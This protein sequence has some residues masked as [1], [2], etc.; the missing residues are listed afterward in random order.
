PEGIVVVTIGASVVLV[1]GVV[2]VTIGASVVLVEVR[3][4][5]EAVEVGR[6]D[7]DAQPSAVALHV[8]AQSG[9]FKVL[10]AFSALN[11]FRMFLWVLVAFWALNTAVLLECS[12]SGDSAP[13]ASMG[14]AAAA[15]ATGGF[16]ATV[17]LNDLY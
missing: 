11:T 2:V 7:L 3:G 13:A 14:P 12:K 17:H 4:D 10:V 5:G 16:T 1:E 6:K 9:S 8:D 15:A